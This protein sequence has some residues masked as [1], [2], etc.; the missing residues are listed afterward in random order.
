M[1]ISSGHWVTG[2]VHTGSKSIRR[3][4]RNT[5]DKQPCTHTLIPRSNLGT[6]VNLM[7]I[8][9]DCIRKPDYQQS[10]HAGGEHAHFLQ[11][12]PKTFLPHANKCAVMQTIFLCCFFSPF[13]LFPEKL[14]R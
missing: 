3:Q 12:Y 7:C 1:A 14:I 6:P 10:R 9:L 13:Y 11:K 2:G 5:Q 8:F 4:H